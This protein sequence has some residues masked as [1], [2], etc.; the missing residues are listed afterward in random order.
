MNKV[1]VNPDLDEV[2]PIAIGITK[3]Q[4]TRVRRKILEFS[5][6]ESVL[7]LFFCPDHFFLIRKNEAGKKEV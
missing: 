6:L 4:S 3:S 7:I 2:V 1:Q 5:G